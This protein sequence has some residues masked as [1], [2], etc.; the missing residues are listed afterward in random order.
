MLRCRAARG[1]GPVVVV[2]YLRPDPLLASIK[3]CDFRVD[4]SL[5]PYNHLYCRNRYRYRNERTKRP[6][7]TFA[8]RKNEMVETGIAIRSR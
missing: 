3:R 7:Q 8:L 5:S 4:L 1:L 6:V 2:S